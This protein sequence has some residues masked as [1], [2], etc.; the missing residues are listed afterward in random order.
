MRLID[1]DLFDKELEE[2][3]YGHCDEEFYTCESIRGM[4]DYQPTVNPYQ[5]ISVKDRLPPLQKEVIVAICDDSGDTLWKYTTCG[6]MVS[7]II[8]IVDNDVHYDVTHWMP[9]PEPPTN[10]ENKL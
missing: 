4:L 10:K 5:W 7:Q 2:Y 1:A 9:L 3:S 6:W 8:W